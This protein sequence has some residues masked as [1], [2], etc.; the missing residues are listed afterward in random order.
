MNER[1]VEQ[2]FERLDRIIQLLEEEQLPPMGL[3]IDC[4][5]T[6]VTSDAAGNFRCDK[7]GQVVYQ[8]LSFSVTGGG[9]AYTTAENP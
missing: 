2:M 6:Q 3:I 5:H 8:T 7:C 4:P 1:Q 9:H